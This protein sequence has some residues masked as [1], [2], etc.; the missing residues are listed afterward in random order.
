MEA[1][2]A[3]RLQTATVLIMEP[4]GEPGAALQI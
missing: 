4:G 1:M 2:I 3:Y